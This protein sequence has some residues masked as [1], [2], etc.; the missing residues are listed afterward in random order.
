METSQQRVVNPVPTLQTGTDPMRELC[1]ACAHLGHS[2]T[3]WNQS[4]L[5]SQRLGGFLKGSVEGARQDGDGVR[6][7]SATV[8]QL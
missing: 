6:A 4:G 1:L 8:T 2:P 5:F 7:F 3:Q